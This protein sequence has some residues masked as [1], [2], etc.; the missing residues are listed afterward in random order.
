[1][2]SPLV[3]TPV[4]NFGTLATL[5]SSTG[6]LFPQHVLGIDR[7]GKMPTVMNFSFTIQQQ[8]G[9]RHGGGRGLRG[10][11]GPPPDVAAQPQRHPVRRQL[12][13]RKTPTPP[14]RAWPSRSGFLR[15]IPGYD[16][17]NLRECAASSNYH[18][19][20]VT[21]NRRFARGL[22]FGALLDLVEG[23]GLQRQRRRRREH[24]GAG[25]GVELR[26]G[27]LRPHPRAQGQLA[28]GRAQVPRGRTVPAKPLLNG[29]QVSGI[30]SF[31]SGAPLGVDFATT[32]ATDITGSP[33]DGARIVVTGNP[34]LPKSERTFSRNFRTDVFRL[35]ARAPSATPP[36]RSSAVPA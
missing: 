26:P 17:I 8:R 28:L 18:S 30:A 29:W 2:Q 27:R 31:I 1:M 21:A 4:I 20:Q 3:Q 36:A 33:T 16:N 7:S 13:S 12:R 6:L 23:H 25:A 11:P 15:P 10:L 32:V 5:P 34:V 24:P 9:L 14:T 19:L 35:P 22:Q